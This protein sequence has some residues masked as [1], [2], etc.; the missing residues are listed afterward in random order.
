MNDRPI[1]I[2]KKKVHGHGRHGGAWKVAYADFVTAMM[3][4]FMVMW[5]VGMS[6]QDKSIIAAY[7]NDPV[8]FSQNP[9][10]TKLNMVQSINPP[11]SMKPGQTM[12]PG[13]DPR[14]EDE[15]KIRAIGKEV[16]AALKADTDLSK[17]AAQVQT[18]VTSEGLRIEL[19]EK[20]HSTFF[21]SGKATLKQ[22]GAK[23]IARIAPVIARTGRLIAI[24]GH[25]DAMPYG[26]SGYNNWDL[27]QDRAAS[28]RRA[29]CS[30]GVDESQLAGV[31][32]YAAT[33]LKDPSNPLAES[34]RRV[35][36]LV[37]FSANA[38]GR[39]DLPADQ[40]KRETQRRL[41][42]TNLRF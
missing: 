21:D 23:L 26:G 10:R 39:A 28:V 35:T 2:K 41:S 17:L 14:K 42:G 11:L 40:L 8:G 22:A 7:F 13:S 20:Q 37:P 18:T 16:G 15:E 6:E 27:S 30:S 32:G 5:I 19:L 24:E 3:A 4:F 31:H 36:I 25:T 33:R 1:I 12:T 34:N 38:K 29:L 9:P